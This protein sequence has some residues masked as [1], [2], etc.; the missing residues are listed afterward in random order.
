MMIHLQTEVRDVRSGRCLENL[1]RTTTDVI[2]QLSCSFILPVVGNFFEIK[3]SKSALNIIF[4]GE[5]KL[6]RFIGLTMTQD[7]SRLARIV[8]AVVEEENN[9]TTDFT[10]QP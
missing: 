6:R 7:S 1:E 10:L 3:G 4:K 9:L 5:V 2:W 8:I